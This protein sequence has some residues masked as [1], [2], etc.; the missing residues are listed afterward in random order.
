MRNAIALVVS[1]LWAGISAI[2]QDYAHVEVGPIIG[3]TPASEGNRSMRADLGGR[4]VANFSR[5]SAVDFQLTRHKTYSFASEHYVA[6]AGSYKLT[7]RDETRSRFNAFG[8]A[9]FGI[10]ETF[11]AQMLGSSRCCVSD[12]TFNPA[13]NLGGGAELCP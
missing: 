1:I 2:A 12:Y 3:L 8:L 5:R 13:M 6:L 11:Y 7:F 9:G 4:L 10:V